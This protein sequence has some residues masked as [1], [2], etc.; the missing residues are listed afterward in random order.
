MF[1]QTT[2]DPSPTVQISLMFK[3]QTPPFLSSIFRA[4]TAPTTL[5]LSNRFAKLANKMVFFRYLY[6]SYPNSS[7]L[8]S[9]PRR[10][11]Y[12][13]KIWK[14][15]LNPKFG[16]LISLSYK[17][18]YDI[19]CQVQNHGMPETLINKIMHTARE[20]FRM[21]ESERL[22]NYSEDPSKSTRLSTSF[23][24]K[25]EKVSNWRDFLRLHCYPL[26]DYVH[27]WPLNPPS[28]RW[29]RV[30]IICTPTLTFL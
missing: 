1:L 5:I 4:Y 18:V 27:E 3:H 22:K 9:L 21:P 8:L 24:V 14:L 23:N 6:C 15:K 10:F 12:L 30:R 26:E 7:L 19:Y 11:L 28:F 2:F 16:I 13:S 20:F 29:V 17:M 25:T